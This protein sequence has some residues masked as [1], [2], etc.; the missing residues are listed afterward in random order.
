MGILSKNTTIGG[1]K[2][3]VN[4]TNMQNLIASLGIDKEGTEEG[5]LA[6]LI[7]N[8]INAKASDTSLG[9]VKLSAGIVAND[10]INDGIAESYKV[11]NQQSIDLNDYIREG[12]YT[13]LTPNTGSC[14]NFPTGFA[15]LSSSYGWHLTVRR[16]YT[17]N[18]LYQIISREQQSGIYYRYRSGSSWSGWEKILTNN[19]YSNYVTKVNNKEVLNSFGSTARTVQTNFNNCI[20]LGFG[21]CSNTNAPHTNCSQWGFLNLPSSNSGNV[22]STAIVQIAWSCNNHSER[23]TFYFRHY[24]GS[25]WTA[26]N[27]MSNN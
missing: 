26:W 20:N 14:R 24:M 1:Y 13:I 12:S 10:S 21:L 11:I 18:W 17:D 16:M 23:P 15:V 2:P 25:S 27:E 6:Q 3:F 9:S 19:N 5:V 7:T 4:D 8:I 22:S